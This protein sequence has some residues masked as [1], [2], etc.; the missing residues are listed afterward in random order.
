MRDG[1]VRERADG[2]GRLVGR[3]ARA[4]RGIR[5]P[6]LAGG[7]VCASGSLGT[8]GQATF[9]PLVQGSTLGTRP[10]RDFMFAVTREPFRRIVAHIVTQLWPC[11][12][13][14]GTWVLVLVEVAAR[15]GLAWPTGLPI[16]KSVPRDRPE[17]LENGWLQPSRGSQ[18]GSHHR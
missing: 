13:L 1:D 15:R 5:D 11:R 18:V 7:D 12:A 2:V 6:C 14:M 4:T 16:I 10:A 8:P 3:E 9:N 17:R